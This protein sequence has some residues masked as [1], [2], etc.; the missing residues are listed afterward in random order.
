MYLVRLAAGKTELVDDVAGRFRVGGRVQRDERGDVAVVENVPGDPPRRKR[1]VGVLFPERSGALEWEPDLGSVGERAPH[2]GHYAVS[3]GASTGMQMGMRVRV[4][5]RMC[6]RIRNRG[7]DPPI[8][9]EGGGRTALD[10]ERILRLAVPLSVPIFEFV[11]GPSREF[12]GGMPQLCPKGSGTV[13]RSYGIPGHRVL[14]G[15]VLP[16]APFLVVVVFVVRIR[17]LF[18][19]ARL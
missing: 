9:Q 10:Q 18:V 14:E 15:P 12:R 8:G 13:R 7:R 1:S 2:R 5:M 17:F 3:V 16:Q 6:R 4:H 19:G 11:F